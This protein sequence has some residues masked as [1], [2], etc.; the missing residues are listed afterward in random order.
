MAI[1]L[2]GSHSP[3]AR[4]GSHSAISRAQSIW[5]RWRAGLALGLCEPARARREKRGEGKRER[6]EKG[7]GLL[8]GEMIEGVAEAGGEL[9]ENLGGVEQDG[10]ADTVGAVLPEMA[11]AGHI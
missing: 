6:R 7:R 1:A 9:G 4:L 10:V 2:T 8:L 11:Q 3:K 5:F